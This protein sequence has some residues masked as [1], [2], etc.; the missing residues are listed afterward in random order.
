MK[1]KPIQVFIVHMWA[2]T[3]PT[4]AKFYWLRVSQGMVELIAF[5]DAR[6]KKLKELKSIIK[7][8]EES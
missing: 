8:I 5:R 3:N 6:E 1:L 2:L 4:R 7:L